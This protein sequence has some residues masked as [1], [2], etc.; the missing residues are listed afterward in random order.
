LGALAPCH[1]FTQFFVEKALDGGANY[2]SLRMT[3]RSC[4]LPLGVCTN[5]IFYATLL[6]LV[7]HCTD[8]RV[9]ELIWS[10]GDVHIYANQIEGAMEQVYRS[11]LP[12]PTI[13]INPNVKDLFAIQRSD[14]EIIDYQHHPHIKYPVSV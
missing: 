4:D 8:L 14:I 10:G 5:L 12:S 9:K 7:A 3:Q 1:V 2:L 11:P 13:K 6:H